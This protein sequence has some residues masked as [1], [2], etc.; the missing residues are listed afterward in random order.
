MTDAWRAIHLDEPKLSFGHDQTADHPKD[1]LFLFGPVNSNQNPARMDV[2]VIATPAG[3]QK[4]ARW[5]A[6]IEK[7]IDVPPP[8]PKRKR[9]DANTFVWPGFEA[10]YGAAWP[11][12]PFATCMIDA[13][14]LSRRIL[15]GDRHQ[16]IYSAVALYEE[17]LRKYLR[18]ED[19]RPTMWFAVVSDE[20][21]KYGRPKS[22]VP[23]KLRTAGTRRLGMKA[24][25]SILTNGSMFAEEIEAAAMYEYELNFRNQLKARLMDTSQVIQVVKEVTLDPPVLAENERSRMQDPATVAWNLSTT[26]FYKTGGKPWRLAELRDGVCYV[27]LVFKRIDR[28]SGR[29][30]ACCGAQMFL[31][32][33]DGLVF[34]GAVGPW[35]SETRDAFHLDQDQAAKLMEMI[36]RS[37]ADIHGSPPTELFIHG[38]TNFDTNEWTGFA[39]AVPHTTKLVGVQIRD[40]ADVKLFRYGANA[41]LRGTAVVTSPASGYLWTR[42]YIPRLRTYPGREVPNPLTVEIRQGTADIEQVMRDVMSLTK[43][44]FNAAEYCDGLPV[45]LRFAD[46]VGEILTAGPITEH[47]PLPFKFYI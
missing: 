18:E 37:Y 38:K 47:A 30:N 23:V 43:L 34:R 44:N 9:N 10:V 41:V 31:G 2:G 24:A 39:S 32:S 17:A 15:G 11:N 20:V 40:M 7:F 29:D 33:G 14:E 4:Y 16:A 45:T 21:F 1:G 28:P 42:G 27:G 35:Y 26:S 6:S 36:V 8:N 3:L 5:V 12:E 46:L 13:A 22:S 25:R 19:A